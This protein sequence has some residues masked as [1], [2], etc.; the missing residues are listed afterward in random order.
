MTGDVKTRMRLKIL[1]ISPGYPPIVG[2]GETYAQII[3]EGLAGRHH[4]TVATDGS[5][6]G[7]RAIQM[8]LPVNLID[9]HE[10]RK[11]LDDP[12]KLPMEQL[13]FGVLPELAERMHGWNPDLV[14]ANSLDSAILGRIVADSFGVPLVAAFHEMYPEQDAYGK[15]KLSVAYSRM[16][17]DAVI[18]GSQYYAE[19]ALQYLPK[20]QVQL[21]RHGVDTAR[22]TPDADGTSIRNQILGD[23]HGL[24]I[25]GIGR[26]K[27]RKGHLELIDAITKLASPDIYLLITG[28]VN[29]GSTDYANML[30]QEIKRRNLSDKVKI[31]SYSHEEMPQVLAAADIVV[32]PSK[33]E[34]LGFTLLEAMSSA[35]AIVA[36]N[37]SGF[38]EILTEPGLAVT[39][40]PEDP[41]AIASAIRTLCDP[42]TRT[43]LGTA[44]RAHIEKNFS[45]TTM[46]R[47]TEEVILG[48]VGE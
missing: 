47:K 33:G 17:P 27:P 39:V 45:V 1:I 21:I 18:A 42:G 4:I 14:F 9:L 3:A 24:L 10:Y 26:L 35:R 30:I 38:N 8:E 31:V 20:Q 22:F 11:L 7:S 6:V 15:G 44:A 2:G 48:I 32:L 46:I 29:S 19:R 40:D 25:A 5:R 16:N 37:V 13:Y 43:L 23:T 12:S 28:T 41:E 36:S 34:G